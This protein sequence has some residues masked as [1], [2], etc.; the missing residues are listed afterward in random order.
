MDCPVGLIVPFQVD[1]PRSDA[2]RD[3][4]LPDRARRPLALVIKLT[5]AAHIH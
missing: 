4:R 2:A 1:A 5:D 3:R